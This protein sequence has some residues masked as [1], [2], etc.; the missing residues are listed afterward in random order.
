MKSKD[1]LQHFSECSFVVNNSLTL[2][3]SHNYWSEESCNLECMSVEFVASFQGHGLAL[4]G[5][6]TVKIHPGNIRK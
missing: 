4:A 5:V 2:L 3:G 1:D 6:G